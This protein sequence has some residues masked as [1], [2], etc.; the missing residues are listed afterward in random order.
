MSLRIASDSLPTEINIVDAVEFAYPTELADITKALQ[1][2]RTCLIECAK[3]L[4][5]LVFLNL[6]RRVSG[7]KDWNFID[8]RVRPSP[9]E[10]S[11]VGAPWLIRQMINS[12]TATV[13]GS[14]QN[15]IV[16]LPHLDLMTS[17]PTGLTAEAKEVIALLHEDPSLLWIGFRDPSLPIPSILEESAQFRCA[18][19][20]VSRPRL[21]YLITRKE[22][23]KFGEEV[24]MG[25]LYQCVSG[26]NALQVRRLLS[27][28][29]RE[30]LP[31]DPEQALQAI[32]EMTLTPDLSIPSESFESIVGMKSAKTRLQNEIILPCRQLDHME[33][34]SERVKAE[35]LI[36][37]GI[38]LSGSANSIK[39]QLARALAHELH[40]IFLDITG[41][42]LMS[43]YLGGSEENIRRLFERA[44]RASPAVIL[45][46]H[47][48]W[49]TS[50]SASTTRQVE[51][52]MVM[53]LVQA[54]EQLSPEERV[55]LIGTLP[56]ENHL[57]PLLQQSG[58]FEWALSINEP[59][60]S[61]AKDI[62][63]S[64]NQQFE[65]HLE[66]K[67]KELILELLATHEQETSQDL[68]HELRKCCRAIGRYKLAKGHNGKIS[69]N[70]VREIHAAMT[71][72]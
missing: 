26:A 44:R 34:E 38:L 52:S 22:A 35:S 61:D 49:L 23:R 36:P 25:T 59:D 41:P 14:I 40:A 64:L 12:L 50:T 2:R 4:A 43:R 68:A 18:L 53:Q 10:S 19:A 47:I 21:R 42:A 69:V 7:E 3:E 16:V 67:A 39:R 8:G 63:D 28:L 29:D 57:D 1:Q 54:M 20:G 33:T 37:R 48:H 65:L 15:R 58:Q 13:R 55:F 72:H 31:A 71:D 24:D 27:V 9:G 30:D 32:R 17:S 62:L 70:Q 51:A 45:F 46:N 5:P 60:S 66:K 11:L 56:D 6:R